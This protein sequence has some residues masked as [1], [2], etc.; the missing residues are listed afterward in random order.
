MLFLICPVEV[1][2]SYFNATV[3]KHG[4]EI[5]RMAWSRQEKNAAQGGTR[6]NFLLHFFA[7]NSGPYSA[8]SF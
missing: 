1:S 2:A 4:R 3:P 6:E 8:S 5:V 7:N